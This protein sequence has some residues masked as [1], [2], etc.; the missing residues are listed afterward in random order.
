MQRIS[1]KFVIW[2]LRFARCL[3]A[4]ESP[5]F[6][7]PNAPADRSQPRVYATV[8]QEQL[9]QGIKRHDRSEQSATGSQP[10]PGRPR[11]PWATR[12]LVPAEVFASWSESQRAGSSAGFWLSPAWYLWLLFSP[13]VRGRDRFSPLLWLVP[14]TGV[15][16]TAM[17]A[18]YGWSI[19]APTNGSQGPREGHSSCSIPE[20]LRLLS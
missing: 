2:A 17:T 20:S 19:N 18:A 14:I 6:R 9:L 16:W 7:M 8:C 5:A 4:D 3:G 10:S 15:L 13:I 1:Y 11:M 12:R